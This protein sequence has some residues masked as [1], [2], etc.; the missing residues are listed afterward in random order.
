MQNTTTEIQATASQQST[1]SDDTLNNPPSDDEGGLGRL[2]GSKGI[3]GLPSPGI[4]YPGYTVPPTVDANGKVW[5]P[6]THENR[7]IVLCFDGT[8]DHFDSDV[9][10]IFVHLVRSLTPCVEL[11]RRPARVHV[12]QRRYFKAARV[13]STWYWYLHRH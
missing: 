9:R 1:R 4:V 8:G 6:E 13:L 7:T 11:E 10:T 5:V 12:V 3:D 2:N